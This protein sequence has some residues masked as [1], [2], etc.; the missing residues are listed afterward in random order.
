MSF[1]N[2]YKAFKNINFK[3]V[4]TKVEK[5]D[6][7]EVLNKDKISVKDF[8]ILLAPQAEEYLEVMAQK[9]RRLTIQN[10]GRVI[11]LYAPLYIANYC[12]NNCAYCG[13]NVTNKCSRRKLSLTEI[14][15]EGIALA[16][17]GIK[18]IL[19][20]T[21]ESRKHSPVSYIKE[22][23]IILKEYFPSVAVEIY[24]LKVNEYQELIQAGVDGLTLYQEVYNE[25]IYDQVHISGPKKNYLYRLN[26]PERGCKAGIRRVNIGALL[27]LDDWRREGFFTGLHAAYLQYKYIETEISISVPRLRPHLGSFNTEVMV[28]D[29]AL[30]QLILAY[31]LFMPRVG[32]NLSTREAAKTRDNL[33]PLGIT[34]ISAESSTYVGGYTKKAGTAQFEIADT[35]SLEEI[36]RLLM[37]KNYQ[38][39]FKDWHQF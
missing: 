25:E 26:G 33:L 22:A 2:R 6:I 17:K 11:F 36:R 39:V 27:G 5:K 29:K 3:K 18:D 10:F 38:P 30:V 7:E 20:L 24:P 34:K 16:E 19:I 9:A 23:V 15:K 1:Y 28:D 12:V 4:Y 32:L 8:M 31:R 37:E 13:F 14:R 35:R 21:G